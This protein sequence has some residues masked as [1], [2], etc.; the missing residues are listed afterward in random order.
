[1]GFAF[2]SATP[3]QEPS[4]VDTFRYSDQIRGDQPF[5]GKKLF[6]SVTITIVTRTNVLG[7][8]PSRM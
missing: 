3:L 4:L 6:V 2:Y 5:V 7:H 1:M 8:R